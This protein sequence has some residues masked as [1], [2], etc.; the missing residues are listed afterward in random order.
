ME[1]KTIMA[2]NTNII[3]NK[4]YYKVDSPFNYDH[5]SATNIVGTS[6]AYLRA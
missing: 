4:I 6:Y 2:V 1:T 3:L 5:Y